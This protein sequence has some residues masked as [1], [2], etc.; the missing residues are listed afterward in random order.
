MVTM[1]VRMWLGGLLVVFGGLWLLDALEVLDAGAVIDRWWPLAVIAL[2]AAGA[3]TQRRLS[4]GPVV[5]MGIGTVLLVD[6]LVEVD[7]DAY[8]W[9]LLAVAVGGWLLVTLGRRGAPAPS[10][11]DRESTFALFGGSETRNRSPHF[12]HANVAAVMGG[13]T[14]D[15]REAHVDPGARVDALALFGG[16]DVIVPQ[17][18]RVALHGLP[19]F[20][21]Y[22]DKTVTDGVLPDDAPVL[23]V[24][25]TAIFGG[26]EVKN[27]RD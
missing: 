20:G 9:P 22:G 8:L 24:N 10:S 7:M 11:V 19:V 5:V 2:G 18:T 13:A 1:A 23:D 21:G 25:A 17:G 16:V 12:Q 14:L 6:Q 4:L 26:V 15:L 3:V 27:A